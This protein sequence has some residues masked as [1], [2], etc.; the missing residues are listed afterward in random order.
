MRILFKDLVKSAFPELKIDKI[1][2]IGEGDTYVAFLIND[3]YLF[4]QAKA[5]EGRQQL[6]KEVS[7]MKSL[8]GSFSISIPRFVLVTP[9]YHFGAY[10]ILPGI[11][12]T[13]YLKRNEF[14][15]AHSEQIVR[16]LTALHATAT[17]TVQDCMLPVM[18]YFEEYEQDYEF[19]KKMPATIFSKKQ[20]EI[21]F[22]TYEYYLSCKDNF[23]YKP[24]LL[25]NDFSFNHII[26]DP[27]SGIITGVID[28]GD[29]AFGDAAYD[30]FFLYELP[31]SIFMEQVCN[32][33]P[34]VNLQFINRIQFYSFANVMQILISCCKEKDDHL[35]NK[36]TTNVQNWFIN[37]AQYSEF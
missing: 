15:S 9:D 13:E 7:L 37:H 28:F 12:F 16:F 36:E 22:E 2:K 24:V 19:V 29:A 18:N 32:L 5:K 10:E 6:K 26:C 14:T 1:K 17:G 21:I 27:I 4:K 30:F 31:K 11:S 25:H 20:K 35:I 3:H 34:G 8:A 23:E 33:Y